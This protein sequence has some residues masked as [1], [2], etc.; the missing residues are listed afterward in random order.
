[1]LRHH[2]EE[3]LHIL[4]QMASGTLGVNIHIVACVVELGWYRR[5]Q[6]SF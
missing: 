3:P 5:A 6:G 1:M 2:V 4:G